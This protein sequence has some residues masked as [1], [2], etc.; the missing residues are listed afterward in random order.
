[1]RDYLQSGCRWLK[2]GSSWRSCCSPCP[3]AVLKPAAPLRARIA[4]RR[5]T[6]GGQVRAKIGDGIRPG[7]NPVSDA[8]VCGIRS[9]WPTARVR[10]KQDEGR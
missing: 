7:T 1:M 10:A 6:S 3:I 5:R 9:R 8:I 4:R 2:S